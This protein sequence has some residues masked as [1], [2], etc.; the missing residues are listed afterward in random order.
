MATKRDCPLE[1]ANHCLVSFDLFG[2]RFIGHVEFVMVVLIDRG[3][4]LFGWGTKNGS[5]LSNHP[6]AASLGSPR[7]S[8]M[9]VMEESSTK[10]VQISLTP[11]SLHVCSLNAATKKSLGSF[12][13]TAKLSTCAQTRSQR[14]P[15]SFIQTLGSALQGKKFMERRVS[16]IS[17]EIALHWCEGHGEP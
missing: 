6:F 15:Q 11:L 2:T 5:T 13:M 12:I 7:Q 17:H 1:T 9:W 8:A 14:V 10:M 3:S 4:A 16:R